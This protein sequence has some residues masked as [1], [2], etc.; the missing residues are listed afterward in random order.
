MA[1]ILIL[2][3]I[4]CVILFKLKNQL[5]NVDDSERE[6]VKKK[7]QSKMREIQKEIMNQTEAVVKKASEEYE[8]SEAVKNQLTANLDDLSKKQLD[9]I[10]KKSNMTLDFFISGAKSAFEMTLKAFS[11]NDLKTLKQLLSE[12]IYSSFEKS[13]QHRQNLG[14]KLVTNLISIKN[15]EVAKV[16]LAGDEATIKLN[17]SSKQINYIQDA[18]DNFIEGSKDEISELQDVWTFKRNLSS[19]NPNWIIFSTN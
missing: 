16:D 1:D 9:K 18:N 5:G 17:F 6:A 2:A 8:K 10:L 15:V 3:I 11:Q 4:A 14:Q 7:M 19:Q 12:K 13:I